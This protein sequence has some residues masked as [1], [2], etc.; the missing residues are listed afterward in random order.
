MQIR[1]DQTGR[2]FLQ[3]SSRITLGAT[4]MLAADIQRAQ[5]ALGARVVVSTLELRR[6]GIGSRAWGLPG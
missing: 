4:F 3:R 2:Q 1:L 5:R 6:G